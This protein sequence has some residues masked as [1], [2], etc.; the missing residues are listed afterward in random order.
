M[1]SF[2][3][4]PLSQSTERLIEEGGQ[5]VHEGRQKLRKMV[6][7]RP[8]KGRRLSHAEE[9][10]RYRVEQKGNKEFWTQLV[11]DERNRLDLPD[12]TVDG[13]PLIPKTVI[14]EMKRLEARHR[15]NS[16]D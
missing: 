8:F 12:E 2:K 7:D 10:Q 4:E 9:L 14:A 13:R 6:G 1:P 15:G 16:E 11:K 3:P 5:R